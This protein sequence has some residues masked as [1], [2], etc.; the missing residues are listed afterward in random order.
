MTRRFS[1]YGCFRKWWYPQIIHFNRVFDYK[2][3]ILGYPYFWKPS[4]DPYPQFVK[5][6]VT[7]KLSLFQVVVVG[8]P[9]VPEAQKT[10][11]GNLPKWMVKIIDFPLWK[12]WDDLGVPLIFGNTLIKFTI[13]DSV[14]GWRTLAGA[15]ELLVFFRECRWGSH[16][17]V[18]GVH[19]SHHQYAIGPSTP[20][21]GKG[22]HPGRLTWNI[23]MEVSK[24]I[25]LSNWVIYRF[26]VN[27]P[28]FSSKIPEPKNGSCHPGG[29]SE[30]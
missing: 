30:S 3:S 18:Q 13:P 14:D 6:Q 20:Q 25:F 28:G 17:L 9:L 24:M 26:H 19:Q 1:G 23:I 7:T 10:G 2:P 12:K 22:L 15:T 16:Q 29:A 11:G 4:F 8:L 27:L 21:C 5:I